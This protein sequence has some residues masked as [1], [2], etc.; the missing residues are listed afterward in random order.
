MALTWGG[1]ALSDR[2]LTVEGTTSIVFL[3]RAAFLCLRFFF[4]PSFKRFWVF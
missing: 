1:E 4:F 3:R 2:R